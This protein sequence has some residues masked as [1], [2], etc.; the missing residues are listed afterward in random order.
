MVRAEDPPKNAFQNP[1][2]NSPQN[3]TVWQCIN[4]ANGL[5]CNLAQIRQV[6]A[7]LFLF[8]LKR[9]LVKTKKSPLVG[10]R[11]LGLKKPFSKLL[12]SRTNKGGCL[13]SSIKRS[14]D[15]QR[16]DYM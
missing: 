6:L 2:S 3:S 10:F 16:P 15:K 9:F 1:F 4:F 5:A 8:C 11:S 12:G 13:D 7:G 14:V